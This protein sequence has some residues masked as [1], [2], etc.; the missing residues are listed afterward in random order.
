MTLHT[1]LRTPARDFVW[2]TDRL[3]S[4]R[5]DYGT[6]DK[7]RHLD[8]YQVACGAWGDSLATRTRDELL[9]RVKNESFNFDDTYGSLRSL[10]L[11]MWKPGSS[12]S[13]PE[14]QQPNRGIIAAFYDKPDMLWRLDILPIPVINPIYDRV[15]AGDK[16]NLGNFFVER[17]YPQS[18]K[19]VNDLILIGVHA[20]TMARRLN[21]RGVGE[22]AVWVYSNDKFRQLTPVEIE[23]FTTLSAKLDDAIIEQFRNAPHVI[24]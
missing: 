18:G 21:T 14:Q 13:L 22:P 24:G 20:T 23:P 5:A 19:T 7:I 16:S 1:V 11:D 9:D 12:D 6:V 4:L 10:G 8:S 15:T 2:I 3:A 17:Y